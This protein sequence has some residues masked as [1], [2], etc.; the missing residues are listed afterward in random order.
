MAERQQHP[1]LATVPPQNLEAE[2]YVLGA[3]LLNSSKAI[4][5]CAAVLGTGEH[6]YRASHQRIYL[7]AM[8]LYERSMPVDPITVAAELEARGQLTEAGG[9]MRVNELAALVPATSNAG[10]Y[11]TLVRDKGIARATIRELEPLLASARSGTLDLGSGLE[12]LERARRQLQLSA[13]EE[14]AVFREVYEFVDEQAEVPTPLWGDGTTT[15]IPAGG[16]VLVAGRPGVGKTTWIVDLCCHLAAG[17]P[18]P[19]GGDERAP[20]P[21]PVARPLRIALIE[22]EGPI[23]MFRDKLGSKLERWGHPFAEAG[24]YLGVQVWRWGAFN[25][26]DP[27]AYA[28][29]SAEL[30]ELQVDLVV[31]DPLSMLGMEGVGSPAETRE[32]VQLIRGLGLGHGRAFL[33]LHHF[34]ERV[35]RHE[36]ELARISGAW[37]GHL[38]TLLTLQPMGAPDEL[39][40]AYPKLRWGKGRTPEPVILGRV[41]ATQAYEALRKESDLSALEPQLVQA[42]TDRRAAG[43]GHQGWSTY[44]QLATDVECRRP[45][46]KAALEG[47]AHLFASLRGADAKALGAKAGNTVLWGLREWPE[48]PTTLAEQLDEGGAAEA[49]LQPQLGAD[50]DADIPF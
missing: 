38:D 4:E 24:G 45:A 48:A 1:E 15:L 5:G 9:V 10:H 19:P 49:H 47:A 14:V 40:M 29:V 31:G 37:G 41:Y 22:N 27:A 34:R 43:K 21:Y 42:L 7:A 25:F 30:D 35:E 6:F 23:E 2:E 11:A 17:L 13:T 32:F 36:D 28:R 18:Y 20:A 46:A 44:S 3:M 39:R 8:S 12:A 16:L 50:P 33:F 26:A